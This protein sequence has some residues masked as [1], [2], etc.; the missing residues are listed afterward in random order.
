MAC[1]RRRQDLPNCLHCTN[2]V[3]SEMPPLYSVREPLPPLHIS[4]RKNSILICFIDS[5]V[6][7]ADSFCNDQASCSTT[8]VSIPN[9][10]FNWR[11]MAGTLGYSQCAYRQM[12]PRLTHGFQFPSNHATRVRL[13]FS[14]GAQVGGSRRAASSWSRSLGICSVGRQQSQQPKAVV[15]PSPFQTIT[16]RE[17]P[18]P[19]HSIRAISICGNFTS[20]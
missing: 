18:R 12:F 16:V 4:S 11:T 7:I 13:P 17:I 14:R 2:C 9:L 6:C 10:C 3:V 20:P 15:H 19:S 8:Q 1:P 5:T